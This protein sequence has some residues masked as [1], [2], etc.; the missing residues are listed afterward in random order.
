MPGEHENEVGVSDLPAGIYYFRIQAG[1]LYVGG[2]MV[3][4]SAT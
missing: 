4:I 3:K 1:E 2:K